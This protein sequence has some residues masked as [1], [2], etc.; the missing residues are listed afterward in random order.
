ML[1][2]RCQEALSILLTQIEKELQ[3]N[4]LELGQTMVEMVNK[5]AE[6]EAKFVEQYYAADV[7]SVEGQDSDDMPAK[8]EGIDAVKAKQA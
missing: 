5:G 3:R 6:E 1:T 2:E 8:I 4:V 7:V